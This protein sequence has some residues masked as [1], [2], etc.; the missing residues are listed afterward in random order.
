MSEVVNDVEGRQ[1]ETTASLFENLLDLIAMQEY[2]DA[3]KFGLH[4][5]KLREVS[6]DAVVRCRC[7]WLMSLAYSRKGDNLGAH[8]VAQE[9]LDLSNLFENVALRAT[10]LNAYGASLANLG[11]QSEAQPYFEEAF[12]ILQSSGNDNLKITNLY[13]LASL[14]LELGHYELAMHHISDGLH[15]SYRTGIYERIGDLE[16][17]KGLI[18]V[19]MGKDTSAAESFEKALR[20]Y[21]AFGL[22]SGEAGSLVNLAEV[23]IRQHK[24]RD[25]LQ[26]LSKA[27]SLAD[28]ANDKHLQD[29]V[30]QT[31]S[32]IS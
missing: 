32:L 27:S 2:A 7:L 4:I 3:I 10:C 13:N 24:N 16:T 31:L 20:F 21:Q 9:A 26:L 17:V 29:V 11:H 12:H 1:S 18:H 5:L 22:A 14:H 6:D 28:S 15:L 25:A 30:K 23:F 8:R 19:R